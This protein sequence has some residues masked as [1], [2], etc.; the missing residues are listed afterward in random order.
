M[1]NVPLKYSLVDQCSILSVE[2]QKFFFAGD[3][4]RIRYNVV[5]VLA[6][7]VL[8]DVI[9]LSKN[10][11]VQ[12]LGENAKNPN[13]DVSCHKKCTIVRNRIFIVMLFFDFSNFFFLIFSVPPDR[14]DSYC[15]KP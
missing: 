11:F 7:K 1:S 8:V 4:I 13:T 9:F 2:N 10:F 15:Q 3:I 5:K 6:K 12:N 14:Y